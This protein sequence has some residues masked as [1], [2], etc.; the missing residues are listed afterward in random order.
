MRLECLGWTK[1]PVFLVRIKGNILHENSMSIADGTGSY[2]INVD[3]P[4]HHR[5]G[6]DER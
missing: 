4:R 6:C 5:G 2:V 3:S 1:V